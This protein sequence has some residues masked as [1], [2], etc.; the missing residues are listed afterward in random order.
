MPAV[1][2]AV[3]APKT[4][5]Q[6]APVA[7]REYHFMLK[8]VGPQALP[9]G[10]LAGDQ[11][12]MAVMEWLNAGYTLFAVHHLGKHTEASTYRGEVYGYHFIKE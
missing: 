11:L 2:E 6:A 3:E 1:K 8:V 7:E 12:D 4:F 5:K 10:T 9:D